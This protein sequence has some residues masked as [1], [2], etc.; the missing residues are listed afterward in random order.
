MFAV[1]DKVIREQFETAEVMFHAEGYPQ[2]NEV[3]QVLKADILKHSIWLPESTDV[4]DAGS[5][6]LH[7]LRGR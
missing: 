6:R 3:L 2:I 5:E 1:L 7:L 4:T